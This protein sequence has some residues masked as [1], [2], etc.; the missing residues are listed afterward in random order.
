MKHLK[1][2]KLRG[3][4]EYD[5]YIDVLENGNTIHWLYSTGDEVMWQEAFRNR[6]MLGIEQRGDKYV[7]HYPDDLAINRNFAMGIDA[8]V[9]EEMYVLLSFLHPDNPVHFISVTNEGGK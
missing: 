2:V 8:D 9:L 3:E 4:H 5:V 6:A 1:K 7:W